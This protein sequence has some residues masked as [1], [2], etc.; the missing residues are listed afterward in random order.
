MT[1][2]A[3][4]AHRLADALDRLAENSGGWSPAVL[5]ALEGLWLVGLPGR[6]EALGAALEADRVTLDDLP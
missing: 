2:R 4:A 1:E 5:A 6:L 3:P